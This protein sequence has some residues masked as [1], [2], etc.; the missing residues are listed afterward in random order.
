MASIILSSLFFLL[1]TS[2]LPTKLSSF[3]LYPTQALPTKSG[4]L[5]VTLTSS[6]PISSSL[7]YAF[8]EAQQPISSLAST[9]L[10]LWL[11]G[12]PGC[13]SMVGNLFELGPW[14]LS[15]NSSS[16]SLYP[17]PFSW[18]RRFGLLFIDNPIG[19]GFSVAKNTSDIPREQS[20][21]AS[22]LWAALQSFLTSYAS[23][24]S[25]PFYVSGESYAGKYVPSISYYILKQNAIVPSKLRIN[26]KGAAIGNGLTHPVVQVATHA[27]SAY[28]TGLI[29]AK[30]KL[31]LESLQDEAVKLTVSEKWEEASDARGTVLDWLQN[32]TGLA[33]LYDMTKKSHIKLRFC[34]YF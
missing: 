14:L 26:L 18:N 8:Y 23:F 19:S 28:F 11:Q 17:N 9:P 16:P 30:Q 1:I 29:N 2:F 27:D 10:L 33:T 34:Q 6:A 5:P 24:R 31:H 15:S 22:H 32:V 21:V 13:S 20:T 12:G 7:Y 25:R 4:Y 3:S